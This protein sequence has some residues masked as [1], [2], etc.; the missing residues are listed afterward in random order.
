M[1]WVW[2]EYV[3]GQSGCRQGGP[4]IHKER[5]ET[6]ISSDIRAKARKL[7]CTCSRN[8]KN[9]TGLK[10]SNVRTL[11]NDK[12]QFIIIPNEGCLTR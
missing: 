3:L 1:G 11:Q 2:S 7:R 5:L 10:S 12:L 6:E 9:F 4:K 8:I